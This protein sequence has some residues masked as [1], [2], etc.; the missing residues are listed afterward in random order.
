MHF[1]AVYYF[2]LNLENGRYV[3]AT[4]VPGIP[5]F[6]SVFT[7][8]KFTRELVMFSRT[9]P[10]TLIAFYKGQIS[11]NGNSLIK[12]V[13]APTRAILASGGNGT[14][15]LAWG[16][17]LDTVPGTDAERDAK[18]NPSP[19]GGTATSNAPLPGPS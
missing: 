14:F 6:K 17:A 10:G 11:S 13:S 19:G 3:S 8:E 16:T 1:C 9:G 4:T 18:R 15:Q 12:A 2:T 5:N 7:V